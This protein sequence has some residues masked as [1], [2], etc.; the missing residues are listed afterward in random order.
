MHELA[1]GVSRFGSLSLTV[2]PWFVVGIA[3]AAV[4]QTF[5]PITRRTTSKGGF[6]SRAG[7][8]PARPQPVFG[9]ARQARP[10]MEASGLR[11]PHAHD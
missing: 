1:Q 4:V 2:L 8:E 11:D 10:H 7:S 3:A 9:D 5:V 6:K